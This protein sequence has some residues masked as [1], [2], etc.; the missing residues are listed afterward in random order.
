MLRIYFP[1]VVA[2]LLLSGCALISGSGTTAEEHLARADALAEQRD[3]QGAAEAVGR[4]SRQRPG[5]VALCLRQGELLEAAGQ[6]EAA[7]KAY[8]R[9]LGEER[10][11]LGEKQELRYRLLLLLT[12]KLADAEAARPLLAQLPAGSPRHLDAQGVLAYVGGRL[13]EALLFFEQAR[14][15][16]A[17]E[18]PRARILYHTALAYERAG[19]ADLARLALFHA[20]NQA[21]SLGVRKDIERFFSRLQAPNP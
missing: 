20:V 9:G 14:D 13:Q 11:D 10:A 21:Q 15:A 1:A 6:P 8:L 12:L 5:D 18:D 2:G 4:A 7:R 17:E 19:D 16:T 3:Y